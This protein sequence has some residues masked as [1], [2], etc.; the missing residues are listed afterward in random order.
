MPPRCVLCDAELDGQDGERI[1]SS[2]VG[3]VDEADAAACQRCGMATHAP[4]STDC[5]YCRTRR[6]RFQRTF[7]VGQYDGTLRDAVL[8][9]KTIAGEPIAAMLGDLLALKIRAELSNGYDDPRPD[10]NF[11]LVTC[12]PAYWFR[13][14]RRGTNSAS[15]IA[16][17]VATKLRLPAGLDLL[18]CRRNIEKQAALSLNERRKNVRAAFRISL[19]YDISEARIL[20]IDDVMTSGAT[21]HEIAKVLRRAGATSVAVAIAARAQGPDW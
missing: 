8:R 6:F 21:A 15:V 5:A 7:R 13:R 12:V 1:C 2:C 14:L 17:V 20:L 4:A 19:G 9:A 11:D 10:H 3:E 18:I 16:K